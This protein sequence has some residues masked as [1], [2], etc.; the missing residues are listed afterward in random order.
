[1]KAHREGFFDRA[2]CEVR[3]DRRA[4]ASIAES[5]GEDNGM[6]KWDFLKWR[7]TLKYTQAEAGQKLGVN[8]GTIQNWERGVSPIPKSVE[9]ACQVLTREWKQR[10][11]FGPVALV[12]ADRPAWRK[13]DD[14]NR[15]ALMHSE[16]CP[17]NDAAFHQ[18]LRLRET[19]NFNNAVI[20]EQDGGIVWTTPEL[21]R[22]CDRRTKEMRSEHE[23]D[24]RIASNRSTGPPNPPD[25]K[26]SSGSNPKTDE[27]DDGINS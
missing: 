22:E 1:M 15:T 23:G 16:P 2:G 10:P 20:I 19:S 14:P 27:H 25:L 11:E 6:D 24:A 3:D 21:L 8:R 18:A 13:P 9:L 12:Y 5:K 7:R 26:P 4:A 17:N